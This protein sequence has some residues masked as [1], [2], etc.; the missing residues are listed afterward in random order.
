[1]FRFR[2]VCQLNHWTC[3]S[4]NCLEKYLSFPSLHKYTSIHKLY[5]YN[6]NYTIIIEDTTIHRLYSY[7]LTIQIYNFT[8]TIQ[9]IP[10]NIQLYKSYT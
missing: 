4:R 9:T 7:T 2:F 8:K 6:I 5:N 1:M 10:K 3:G